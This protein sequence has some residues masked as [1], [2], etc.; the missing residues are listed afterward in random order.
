[1]VA[2]KPARFAGQILDPHRHICAFFHDD[3]EQYKVLL[4]F[5]RDGLECGERAFH[6]V[7]PERR[8]AHL[9]ALEG[10]GIQF[11]AL[12]RDG[13]LQVRVWQDAYLRFGRFDQRAM[14]AF[15]EEAL[16]DGA[17]LGYSLTRLVANME[18][19]LGDCPG[20]DDLVE[21]EARLNHVLPKY[22]DPVICTYDLRRFDAGVV[23]DIL[24]THPAAVI[25]GVIQENPFFVPPDEFLQELRERRASASPA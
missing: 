14:L 12:E 1:M 17:Q 3:A 23:V 11:E 22:D 20:V 9:K 19:A 16:K 18:W 5:I 8:Q 10:S 2:T 21:Y 24:R 7:D 6:I 13:Q 15:I 4:P 25:G